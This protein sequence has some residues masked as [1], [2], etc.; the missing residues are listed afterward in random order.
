MK[1]LY[2][3]LLKCP[4]NKWSDD[5]TMKFINIYSPLEVL[6]NISL[7]NYKN[8]HSRQMAIEK[9]ATEMNIEGFSVPEIKSKINTIFVQRTV[10]K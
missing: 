5:T 10:R 1:L 8:K 7:P 4:I 6:W 2:Y 9:M 3:N